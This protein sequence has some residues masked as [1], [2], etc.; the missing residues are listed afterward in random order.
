MATTV[1]GTI[2]FGG[3]SPNNLFDRPVHVVP[4]DAT[5]D[6]H[7][8][9][10]EWDATEIR[11]YVDDVMYPCRTTG[12]RQE[13]RFRLRSISP[14]ISF[15]MWPL[16]ATGQVLPDASTVFPVTMDVD[17]VRVY[18]GEAPSGGGDEPAAAAPTPTADPANVI[19]LFSD[20]YTDIAGIDYNPDWGQATVVTQEDI[21]GNN[22]LKY[23]GLNYQGTDFA[24]NPQDVSGMDT[25]HVDFWTADSTALNVSLISS[26]PAETAYALTVMPN[27]WVSVDIPLTEFAGVDL[28]DVIQ[29]KFDGNGTV[30]LDNLYFETAGGSATE[31]TEAAPTPTADEADV[32]SLFS[33]AY[34][35]IAGINYNPD[36]GQATVVTQE[37]V[38]GNNTLK[39]AGLDYQG[40]DFTGNPQDVSGMETLH[41]DF[42]TADSTALNISLISSGP[43]ETP[44]MLTITPNT[45]VSVDIPLTAFAGVDLTDVIQV[46]VDGNGTVWLD[47][48]H[49]EQA[50]APA[51]EP[52][53]AAPTPTADAADVISLFSD[54]YTDIA[55]INYN[56]DWGQATVVTQEDVAGNNTLKYANLNY[57]GTDFT[58]NSQDVSGM[59]TLH[60][61][62]WTADST[63][64]NISLISTGPVEMAY[65]LTITPGTWVSVDIPLTAFAGVD[66]A[67]IIQLK[68]D[69]NGT[70]W[71]D[72]LYFESA[73][74]PPTEPVTA[75][76][77][78]TDDPANV[79]SLF[80]DAYTDIAGIDYNPNWGQATVVTQ[81][82]IAGNNTLKYAG[83]NYQGTD[84]SGNAQD[85]SGMDTLHVD[86]W[87][88]DSTALNV[89]LI[90]PGPAETA[91]ALTVTPYTWVS[92]DIPLTAFAGVDLTDVI[93]L[94]FDGNGTIWLDNLYFS[95]AGGGA[96]GE[97][98]VNGGFETGD[99][100]DWAQFPADAADPNEQ[101]VVMTNP[102]SG[103]Y[104][105]RINNTTP[106]TASIIK[107]AN[108]TPV[109]IGQTATV[110]FSARG[111][112]GVGG[113]AFAEFFTELAGEGISS[114]QILGGGPLG[115]NADANVWTDFTFD[116]AITTDVSGG[117]TLQLTG[118]TGG[119]G[120][121]FADVYYD[122][123][124][125]V[126][127]D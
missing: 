10:I 43:V 111:S 108:L 125:I 46:K 28:T 1:Y 91:Y 61:D 62:F 41:L 33:D 99:L 94:K 77:T 40:T 98:A 8:Y 56:P 2:H 27:T 31:P 37:D 51:T 117:I 23:A 115:L 107:Q 124:S 21:A 90:S 35:D 22:T 12:R 5:A 96:G 29:I 25:L 36:W 76:P 72:N 69:G 20:A 120:A 121:S 45:W 68:F 119:D 95:T 55:G 112:F 26:A 118:T 81:E 92:V 88:A 113:V 17:W 6:F 60:V 47:N 54:A 18:S 116:I 71:L 19:S 79:I 50:G 103:T 84:F 34:T 63:A 52:G 9:A 122:D 13:S 57:Q 48:L 89:S 11:W 65:A 32:I 44:Y 126:A 15:S 59:G 101:T 39:Y 109:S 53:T 105:G 104:A 38:A 42:W 67:D 4:T 114:S 102:K 24:G 106:G 93:Q 70:I 58:G 83:L 100:S 7:T 30:W 66:L 85:V 87:T 78:P 82:D 3:E 110:S 74:P 127:T 80:S 86:F 123:I 16:A 64:L 97:L 73:G 75:A 14:S 49:F